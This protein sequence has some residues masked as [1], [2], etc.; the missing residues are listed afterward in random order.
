[1]SLLNE[2]DLENGK[3]I[4]LQLKMMESWLMEK[5]SKKDEVSKSHLNLL[6]LEV[7]EGSYSM[8]VGIEVD[9]EVELE[10]NPNRN[11]FG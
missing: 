11:D 1:M 2:L 9:V 6:I 4:N 8:H 7:T 10:T 5:K 3:R